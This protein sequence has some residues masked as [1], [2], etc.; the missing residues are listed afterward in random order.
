L[1]VSLNVNR[2]GFLHTLSMF[3]C[4]PKRMF[5]YYYLSSR[6]KKCIHIYIYIYFTVLPIKVVTSK[7]MESAKFSKTWLL[8]LNNTGTDTGYIIC[9]ICWDLVKWVTLLMGLMEHLY[10]P[11]TNRCRHSWP[12]KQY[13]SGNLQCPKDLS[14]RQ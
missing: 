3:P 9:I 6:K 12:L 11:S 13:I 1:I 4:S 2:M 8:N 7:L 5:K 14:P 10:L